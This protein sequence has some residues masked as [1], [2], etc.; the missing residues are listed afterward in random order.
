MILLQS[1]EPQPVIDT[2][3]APLDGL[4][5]ALAYIHNRTSASLKPQGEGKHLQLLMVIVPGKGRFYGEISPTIVLVWNYLA[6]DILSPTDAVGP[7][8]ILLDFPRQARSR[9]SVRP[10]WVSFPSAANRDTS[11]DAKIS[12][13]KMFR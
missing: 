5:E 13:W 8:L 9:E 2:H 4:E 7:L 12:I 11:W 6:Q 10:S 3:W 1:F